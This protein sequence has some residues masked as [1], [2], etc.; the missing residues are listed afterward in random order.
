MDNLAPVEQLR[1]MPTQGVTRY[2]INR[3]NSSGTRRTYGSTLKLF[4][5]WAK[6]DYRDVTP[7]N[8][9]D[10]DAYLKSY[11]A[12]STVQRQISTLT[13]FFGFAHKCGLIETNPFA[14][15]KQ[16]GVPNRAAEKFLSVEELDRL[17]TELGKVSDRQY[18]LGLLLASLGLRI[19]EARELSHSDFITAPDGSIEVRVHRKRDK[20]QL[21]PLREDVWQV[22]RDYLGHEPNQFDARPVFLNPSG[23]RISADGMRD[24][25]EK[26][27]KKA[28]ITK[29]ITPHWIRHSTAT[30]LLDQ[31]ASLENVM[32][33]LGH[34]SILTTKIYLHPTDKKISEKMPI[35]ARRRTEENHDK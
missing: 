15:V 21:L 8:A 6:M 14:V 4:F 29:P 20:Y 28:K 19:A 27:A 10:Y 17:L 13:R 24:W 30:H 16:R 3:E 1:I 33:L 35:K 22:V 12:A 32:W 9:L 31:G 2:F 5:A 18:V 23:N 7:F 34:S 25:V 11:C 26:A